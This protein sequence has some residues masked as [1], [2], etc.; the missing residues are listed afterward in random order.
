MQS[1][2]IFNHLAQPYSEKKKKVFFYKMTFF[3]LGA[4]LLILSGVLFLCH[5]HWILCDLYLGYCWLLKGIVGSF[6]GF[7][8]VT[9]ILIAA[10]L[11]VETE[12]VY[13]VWLTAK[14]RLHRMHLTQ[15]A[16]AGATRFSHFIDDSPEVRRLRAAYLQTKHAMVEDKHR[17]LKR[18]RQIN[19]TTPRSHLLWEQ[20]M[21]ETLVDYETR[22]IRTLA[23]FDKKF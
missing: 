9:S 6:A 14:H 5:P 3:N 18:L 7:L 12:A 17:V 10:Q 2:T 15:L 8:G 4:F 16:A 21:N 19:Q 13:Q 11:K 22:T 1:L 20:S 23:D